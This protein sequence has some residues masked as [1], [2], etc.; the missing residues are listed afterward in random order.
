MSTSP[1]SDGML[2]QMKPNPVIVETMQSDQWAVR[3]KRKQVS[4]PLVELKNLT[5]PCLRGHMVDTAG[6][7][8]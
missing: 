4:L 1:I 7:G 3:V 5:T 2:S 6:L 8:L